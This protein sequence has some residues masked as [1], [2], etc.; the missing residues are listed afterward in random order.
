M[1]YI[2][3]SQSISKDDLTKDPWSRS[4]IC[5]SICDDINQAKIDLEKY[6]MSY[7]NSQSK[8]ENF[9]WIVTSEDDS[10]VVSRHENVKGYIFGTSIISENI[11]YFSIMYFDNNQH[12]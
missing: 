11:R 9:K 5:H 12:E 4:C 3:Y 2:I 8:Q 1:K 10:F 6:A 7:M